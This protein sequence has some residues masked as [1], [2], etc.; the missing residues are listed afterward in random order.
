MREKLIQPSE[1]EFSFQIAG[2]YFSQYL[3]FSFHSVSNNMN[4]INLFC[5]CYDKLTDKLLQSQGSELESGKMA[6]QFRALA[7]PSAEPG[8]VSGT[9]ITWLQ[10]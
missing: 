6:Q 7:A 2:A 4:I 10:C 9:H 5:I 8:S 1:L 3:W